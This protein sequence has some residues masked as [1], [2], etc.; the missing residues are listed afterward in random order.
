MKCLTYGILG[1]PTVTQL[2][3]DNCWRSD[4]WLT[5]SPVGLFNSTAPTASVEAIFDYLVCSE[6]NFEWALKRLHFQ[7]SG[8]EIHV[9]SVSLELMRTQNT[10]ILASRHCGSIT[11]TTAASARGTV[12][13]TKLSICFAWLH[14]LKC[15]HSSSGELPF[16]AQKPPM[17]LY[18]RSG[19]LGCLDVTKDL[20]VSPDFS[21]QSYFS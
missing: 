14:T 7:R 2:P 9:C 19:E 8:R 5:A 21:A 12:I 13:T 16:P 3:G 17:V 20:Y 11:Y 18:G 10:Y 4:A 1:Q 15:A 6:A